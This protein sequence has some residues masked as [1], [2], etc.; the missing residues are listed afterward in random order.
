MAY[1]NPDTFET[2]AFLVKW[3]PATTDQW[4]EVVEWCRTTIGQQFTTWTHS[5]AEMQISTYWWFKEES[6]SVLFKMRWQ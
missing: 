2:L 5:G 6:D 1:I 3:K 4:Q